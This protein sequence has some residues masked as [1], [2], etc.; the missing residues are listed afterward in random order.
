M[1]YLLGA[2]APMGQRLHARDT[3]ERSWG[4]RS[5]RLTLVDYGVEGRSLSQAQKLMRHVVGD[6]GVC[7]QSVPELARV[8]VG[9][10]R[11]EVLNCERVWTKSAR[12]SRLST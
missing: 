7:P 10:L 5:L 4:L 2:T 11:R 12:T 3:L 6:S 9:V 1:H 8:T